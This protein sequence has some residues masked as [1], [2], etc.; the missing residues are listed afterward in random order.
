MNNDKKNSNAS[1]IFAK[2]IEALKKNCDESELTFLKDEFQMIRLM[3]G[4]K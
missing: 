3:K 2:Q 1:D 4:V